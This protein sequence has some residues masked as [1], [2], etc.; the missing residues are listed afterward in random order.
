MRKWDELPK[1]MRTDE[2][3]Q[4]YD[5][6]IRHEKELRLKRYFD[7]LL[8]MILLVI[9]SPIMLVI[10][11]AIK[12]DSPGPVIY[13]QVRVTQYGKKFHILKFRTMVQN[14]D[15]M[16]TQ[17][18]ISQDSRLTRVGK[19]IRGCRID[20]FPQLINVLRGEM[21]FV[22]TRPEVVKYVKG[23]TKEMYATLLLP[24]G[25]T[26]RASVCYKDEGEMLEHVEDVDYAYIHEVLPEKMSYNPAQILGLTEKGA[27]AEGKI[28]DLVIFDPDA[29]Y[30]ID[31]NTFFSKGKN[32][33]FDGRE[34]YGR[35]EYTLADGEI[36]YEYQDTRKV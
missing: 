7:I 20:E 10:S 18:T 35:V 12:L 2:V 9:L 14:A 26:S 25:I 27:V 19:V 28:A 11:I 15:K 16:G 6:L 1:F 5:I 32:T 34:V 36:V 33:P 17:V 8:S 24:A 31:K 22:G 21:S 4:Y 23:Y 3:K 13:K 30:K 29:N